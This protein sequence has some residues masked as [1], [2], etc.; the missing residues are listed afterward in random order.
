MWLVA[1]CQA[2]QLPVSPWFEL[3]FMVCSAPGKAQI[4]LFYMEPRPL[5]FSPVVLCR[6]C[7]SCRIQK[8][9]SSAD[10]QGKSCCM[11]MISAKKG[12]GSFPHYIRKE[13][14]VETQPAAGW[15]K[16]TKIH[17]DILPLIT[18][19]H[20]DPSPWLGWAIQC[21][22]WKQIPVEP[23][24]RHLVGLFLYCHNRILKWM[25]LKIGRQNWFLLIDAPSPY[26]MITP[27]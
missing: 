13:K 12:K 27:F 25:L 20:L 24:Q 1:T 7:Q 9:K 4:A 18:F 3:V 22:F 21:W 6:P 26:R 14:G 23:K 19:Q 5:P 16:R 17:Q 11:I 8:S 10:S 2:L 15:F